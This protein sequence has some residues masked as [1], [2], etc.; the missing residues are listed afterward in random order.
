MHANALRAKAPARANPVHLQEM[1]VAAKPS[2]EQENTAEIRTIFPMLFALDLR[3]AAEGL[4]YT[5]NLFY[6]V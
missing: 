1:D 5:T 3:N 6:I 4:Y 2:T